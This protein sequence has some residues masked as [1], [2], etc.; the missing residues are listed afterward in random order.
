MRLVRK[1]YESTQID[2]NTVVVKACNFNNEV[3]I[4]I[5]ISKPIP[6]DPDDHDITYREATKRIKGTRKE[7]QIVLSQMRH[8]SLDQVKMIFKRGHLEY[9]IFKTIE[10]DIFTSKLRKNHPLD[11]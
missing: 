7:K 4:V 10:T 5:D 8:T 9:T 6:M 11:E 1:G 2:Q 3:T